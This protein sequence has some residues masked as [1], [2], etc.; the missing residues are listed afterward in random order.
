MPC[1][2]PRSWL[3]PGK[4]QRFRSQPSMASTINSAMS[5]TLRSSL[6]LL[7]LEVSISWQKEQ[8]VATRS[9][10]VARASSMRTSLMRAVPP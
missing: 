8:A 10:P 7:A 3:L 6:C 5:N 9:A 2:G 4:D 1:V